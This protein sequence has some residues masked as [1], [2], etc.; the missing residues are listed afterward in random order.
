MILEGTNNDYSKII[1]L[2]ENSALKHQEI[3]SSTFYFRGICRFLISQTDV[4]CQDW[5][6]SG[7]LGYSKSYKMISV[8]CIDYLK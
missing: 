8:N 3:Y 4:A 1:S 7:E 5:S 2:S 6:R